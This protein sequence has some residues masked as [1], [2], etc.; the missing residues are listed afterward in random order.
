MVQL[1]KN[2]FRV[3]NKAPVSV[4]TGI[5][6]EAVSASPG[7][8]AE[9]CHDSLADRIGRRRPWW[10]LQHGQPESADGL[11]QMPGKDAIAIMEEVSVT[12]PEG[13]CFP[14]LL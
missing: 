9:S 10:R 3:H 11:V 7:T 5:L 2:R 12:V 8:G 14:Q 1:A 6:M 4:M 13:D